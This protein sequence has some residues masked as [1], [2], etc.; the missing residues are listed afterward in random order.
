MKIELEM[1][2]VL[3]NEPCIR[4]ENRCQSEFGNEKMNL[5]MGIKK[6]LDLISSPFGF[7][8]RMQNISR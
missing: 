8:C 6:E 4:W 2:L 7:G 5:V 1:N 3:V